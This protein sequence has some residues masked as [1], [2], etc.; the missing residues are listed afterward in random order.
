MFRTVT[1]F[2]CAVAFT[3]A[4]AVA[5]SEPAIVTA[6][7]TQDANALRALAGKA[8][9]NARATDGSTALL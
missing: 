7:R 6:A 1:N 3:A 4:T 9:V 2:V 8:D 5:Q